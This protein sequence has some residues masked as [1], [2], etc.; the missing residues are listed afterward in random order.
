MVAFA[1]VGCTSVTPEQRTALREVS[2]RYA[3]VTKEMTQAQIVAVLGTPQKEDARVSTWEARANE[4]NFETLV[5]EFDPVGNVKK[6]TRITNRYSA[7][8]RGYGA[9]RYEYAKTNNVA[10]KR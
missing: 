10:E 3:R 5:V 4:S 8:P 1:L 7:G 6:M 2:E 9:G